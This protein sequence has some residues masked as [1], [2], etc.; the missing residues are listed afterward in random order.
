MSKIAAFALSKIIEQIN[1]LE[2]AKQEN[3]LSE[4]AA[5]IRDYM[6]FNI[7]SERLSVLIDVLENAQ[8]ETA[9]CTALRHFEAEFVNR[10]LMMNI[11]GKLVSNDLIVDLKKFAVGHLPLVETQVSKH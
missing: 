1:A 10:N 6:Y 3:S 2:Q 7:I 9:T 4:E 5:V 11:T 8:D